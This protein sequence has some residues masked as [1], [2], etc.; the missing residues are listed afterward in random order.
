MTS[1]QQEDFSSVF[2]FK[3]RIDAFPGEENVTVAPEKCELTLIC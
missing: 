1:V 2:L 3:E